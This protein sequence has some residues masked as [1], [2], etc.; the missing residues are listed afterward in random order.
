MA[1]EEDKVID[2]FILFIGYIVVYVA[3]SG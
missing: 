2:R 1:E 3:P